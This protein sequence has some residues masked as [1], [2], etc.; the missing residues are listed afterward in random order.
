MAENLIN[1]DTGRSIKI[2]GPTYL[3]LLKE[4]K[5]VPP[6]QSS[7]KKAVKVSPKKAV[8]VSPKKAVKV[9]PKKAVAAQPVPEE[10]VPPTIPPHQITEE[11][12][13]VPF[14][15]NLKL[16]YQQKRANENRNRVLH[17]GQRKLLLSEIEFLTMYGDL[18]ET[19][20]YVG[21]ANGQH[22][23]LLLEMFPKHRFI[24]YDPANFHPHTI[25]QAKAFPQRLT[26]VQDYFNDK[27][28]LEYKGQSVLYICDIRRVPSDIKEG[29]KDYEKVFA[30]LIEEDMTMQ[31]K[32]YYAMRPAATMLKFRPQF[33]DF[34]DP[35]GGTLTY[36]AGRVYRQVWAPPNSTE[37]RLIVVGPSAQQTSYSELEYEQLMCYFNV[38][39]RPSPYLLPTNLEP[40]E[41][42]YDIIHYDMAGELFILE[43][44]VKLFLPSE[45][46]LKALEG[47][48]KK[49]E[50][51]L[52]KNFK[53]KWVEYRSR[54][55]PERED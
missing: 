18:S 19:V 27:I 37:A 43:Q 41:H 22:I 23:P 3:R 7:P 14:G 50:K 15:T 42:K 36:L 28:A 29:A 6:P 38:I 12:R 11:E 4:G 8:K 55:D 46:V 17:W 35:I 53:R 24:L 47:L 26:I 30:K 13:L 31:Q 33:V 40:L 25:E 34:S 48:E 45:P 32:W 9:S 49:I 1:P 16:K 10:K 44:Y 39:V 51:I 20:V 54:L 21:A 2:G 52:N 5:I